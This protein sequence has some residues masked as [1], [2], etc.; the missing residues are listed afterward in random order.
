MNWII[1]YVRMAFEVYN[2]MI[3]IR[4]FLS[5]IPHNPY[6]PVFRFLY[7]TTEPVLAPFRRMMGRYA[8]GLDFS[9]VIALIVLQLVE[10]VVL[11][12]LSSL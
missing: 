7:E 9:P 8:V 5:W 4:V 10:S 1:P 12:L 3:I 11:S 6:N 2:W